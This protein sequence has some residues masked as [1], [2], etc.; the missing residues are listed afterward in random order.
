[1]A[2][3][4]L[5]G[6]VRS[7]KRLACR[8]PA[9]RQARRLRLRT[10]PGS[11]EYR[12]EGPMC[13]QIALCNLFFLFLLAAPALAQMPPAPLPPPRPLAPLLYV[14][15]QGPAGLKITF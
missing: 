11:F 7:R 1:M 6:P 2:A 8:L 12:E 14:R 15:L 4:S 9:S 13:K 10:G 5:P 3:N